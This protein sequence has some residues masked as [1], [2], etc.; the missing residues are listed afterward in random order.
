M[1]GRQLEDGVSHN[2]GDRRVRP[3][4]QFN[5]LG[6]W[7]SRAVLDRV[8]GEFLV[9]K[10]YAKQTWAKGLDDSGRPIRLPNTMPSLEGTPVWPA[11]AGA[12]N[13]YSPSYSRQ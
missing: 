1:E 8:T 12:N 2:V 6:H 7:E 3:A 13:W 9:G 11:V 10:A 4:N 5:L